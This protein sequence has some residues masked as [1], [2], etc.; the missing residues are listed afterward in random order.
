MYTVRLNAI[1]N[2]NPL[3]TV[4]IL[5]QERNESNLNKFELYLIK[6]H[7]YLYVNECVGAEG[8]DRIVPLKGF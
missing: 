4:S 6:H 5:S 3:N 2:F 1:V 8:R 7:A